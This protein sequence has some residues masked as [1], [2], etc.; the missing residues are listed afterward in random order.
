[1]V[2]RRFR[3]SRGFLILMALLLPMLVGAAWTAFGHRVGRDRAA[4]AAERHS[5]RLAGEMEEVGLQLGS[6]AFIRIFKAAGELEL[7]VE[8]SD[9]RYQHFRSYPICYFSGGLGPKTAEGDRMSPEG[10][11][12]VP[13]SQLNP[14]SRYHLAFNLGF[15]NEVEVARGWTGSALMVHGDC[16]SIGCYAMGNDAI[17]EIYVVI[18]S[19]LEA[20]QPS[21]L[22]HA[23]PFRLSDEA[24]EEHRDSEWYEFWRELQPFYVAFENSRVPAAARDQDGRY[25]IAE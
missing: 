15:P 12:A 22:V 10:I 25:A 9:G 20:G 18:E 11:Y 2:A 7:W 23:F 17:E 4:L 8:G 1:M 16:V 3:P 19:A 21:V 5:A 24:L 13:A 6:A 14:W